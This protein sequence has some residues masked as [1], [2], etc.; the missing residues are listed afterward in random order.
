MRIVDKYLASEN[1]ADQ[2]LSYDP[3]SVME[4][5]NDIISNNN[6]SSNIHTQAK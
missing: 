3:Q 4:F 2:V 5:L 1:F 6:L